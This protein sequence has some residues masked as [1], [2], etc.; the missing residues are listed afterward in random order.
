MLWLGTFLSA[1]PDGSPN[2]SFL[3]DGALPAVTGGG[4]G[5]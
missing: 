5:E 3:S 4:G 1:L 2:Q